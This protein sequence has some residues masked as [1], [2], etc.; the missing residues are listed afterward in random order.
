MIIPIALSFIPLVA[1]YLCFA[2]LVKD[3]KKLV[4]ILSCLLGLLAFIPI[5]GIDLIKD[6][7]IDGSQFSQLVKFLGLALVEEGVKMLLL[8]FIPSKK[9]AQGAFFA[10]SVLLGM[11]LGCFETLLYIAVLHAKLRWPAILVHAIC[12]GLSGIFVYSIKKKNVLITSFIFAVLFH[13]VYNYLADFKDFRNYFAYVVILI[14]LVECKLRYEVLKADLADK[15]TNNFRKNKFSK[16]DSKNM[17]FKDLLGK[18][19]K[20]FKKDEDTEKD[21][22]EQTVFSSSSETVSSDFNSDKTDE[23]TVLPEPKDEEISSPLSV[24]SSP[25]PVEEK[26]SGLGFSKYPP[27]DRLFNEE[28][29]PEPVKAEPKIEIEP[30]KVDEPVVKKTRTRTSTIKVDSEETEPVKKTTRTRTAAKASETIDSEKTPAKR[31][32]KPAAAKAAD[33]A[34]KTPAKRGRKPAAAKAAET[35]E[36]TPAKRGRKPAAAKTEETAE[37]KPATRGRKPAAAKATDT[38]EKKPATRGRKPAAAKTADT[39]EK[40]PATRGRKPAASKATETVAAK[41]TG[42]AKKTT[43][44]TAKKTSETKPTAAKK[45]TAKKTTAKKTTK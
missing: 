33:D 6:K 22:P 43:K 26:S 14:A 23:A 1:A 2:L 7:I 25:T 19:G 20:F 24:S 3:F 41:T 15:T 10:Y 8:F 38:A 40:K 30:V 44:T 12:A 28:D 36:K 9:T 5:M 45:T 31:G 35:A 27:I 16:G 32:R 18:V 34:E 11:T 13:G 37:K 39:A 21:L 42:A 4:G 17:G 29:V